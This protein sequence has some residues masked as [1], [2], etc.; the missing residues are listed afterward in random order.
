[1]R[2][3]VPLT[4]DHPVLVSA[5][6]VRVPAGFPSPAQDSFDDGRIDLNEVL[7]RDVTSTYLFRVTGDSMEGIGIYHGDEVLV[8]RSLTPRHGDGWQTVGIRDVRNWR[9]SCLVNRVAVAGQIQVEGRTEGLELRVGDQ[10]VDEGLVA[11]DDG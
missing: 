11:G 10:I 8:D 4:I 5:V 7:I 6:L 3:P 9:G 1:M 2:H